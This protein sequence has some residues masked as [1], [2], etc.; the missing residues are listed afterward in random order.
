MVTLFLDHDGVM[1]TV[2]QYNLTHNSKSWLRTGFNKANGIYPFDKKAVKILNLILEEVECEIVVSSDW[3]TY[4]TLEQL[5][6]IY[7]LCG[8]NQTP[9]A[10]TPDHPTS[11]S[12]IEKNRAGEIL[13]YVKEHE[14][15]KY[16]AIDD[17]D[18]QGFLGKEHFQI[19]AGDWEGIKKSGLKDKIIA[20]LKLL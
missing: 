15:T 13:K 5:Q 6:E 11:M 7:E 2:R 1:C 10:V 17:L 14:L 16:F 19:T 3:K 12:H 9:I 18:L 4:G 20:K 8:V